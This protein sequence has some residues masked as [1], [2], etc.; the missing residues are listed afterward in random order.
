MRDPREGE[1]QRDAEEE[2][3]PKMTQMAADKEGENI[4]F[5]LSA[6]ICV[7]FG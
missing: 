3:Q 6:A 7:I 2:D 1:P 5:F 4:L